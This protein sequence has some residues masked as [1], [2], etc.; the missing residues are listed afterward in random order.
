MVTRETS[1]ARLLHPAPQRDSRLYHPCWEKIEVRTQEGEGL[2]VVGRQ[3]LCG[4]ERSLS[5]RKIWKQLFVLTQSFDSGPG[6]AM[7]DSR[8]RGRLLSGRIGRPNG[9]NAVG[10]VDG[11]RAP[12]EADRAT[13]NPQGMVEPSQGRSRS[14]VEL[15]WRTPC[16]IPNRIASNF[17]NWREAFPRG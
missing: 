6:F 15:E 3:P 8:M 1:S 12:P 14:G 10:R 4:R 2:P 13:A 7:N 16:I 5:G 11:Q 17:C 9:K